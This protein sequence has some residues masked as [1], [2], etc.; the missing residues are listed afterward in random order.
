[1]SN[2]LKAIDVSNYQSADL[3]PLIEEY[4]PQLVIVRLSTESAQHQA[5][6][7]QQIQ[8]AHEAGCEVAGYIWCYWTAH[9]YEYTRYALSLYSSTGVPFKA[10]ML[11]CEDE[12]GIPS[13]KCDGWIS[14]SC[15]VVEE[16][17]HQCWIYTRK[18]WWETNVADWA[19]FARLP[20]WLAHYDND[21][22]LED[23]LLPV[24]AWTQL[25][26]KQF[27]DAPL[28]LSVFDSEAFGQVSQPP[29]E[30]PAD[31]CADLKV[32]ITAEL[33]KKRLNRKKIAALVGG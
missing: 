3:T 19:A 9:S 30:P 8:T 6:A 29:V 5:I 4:K 12:A 31:P 14:T 27:T 32:A 20:L 22:S 15:S 17:G 25:G 7:L 23:P 26:G 28:D 10:V 1:M 16:R 18:D 13:V 2:L 33:Q 11:D 21:P 24:G